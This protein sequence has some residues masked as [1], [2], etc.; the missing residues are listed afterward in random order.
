MLI[1]ALI[2]TGNVDH[3]SVDRGN[4]IPTSRATMLSSAIGVYY[5][6]NVGAPPSPWHRPV[7]DSLN[8]FGF[9]PTE[10]RHLIAAVC[11]FYALKNSR[12]FRALLNTRAFQYLGRVSFSVYLLHTPIICSL[13][14]WT[15]LR[16]DGARH[17]HSAVLVACAVSIAT[18]YALGTIFARLVDRPGQRLAR[19]LSERLVET[20]ELTVEYRG[21]R[22]DG[23]S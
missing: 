9:R 6:G 8:W 23:I 11:A 13:G 2:A 10:T 19:R 20:D 16:M 18:T 22:M 4:D 1:G 15:F 3:F 14:A 17:Y 7:V 21:H 12:A 5:F